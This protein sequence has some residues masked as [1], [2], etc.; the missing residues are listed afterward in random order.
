[1]QVSTVASRTFTPQQ[2]AKTIDQSVLRQT[3]TFSDV[4]A[5]AKLSLKHG[6]RALVVDPYYAKQARDL[7]KGSD[8]LCASVCDFPHGRE[9]T[10]TRVSAVKNLLAI[11]VDEVDIVAKYHLLLEN[12]VKDFKEDIRSVVKAMSGVPLKIIL[13]VDNLTP[14]QIKKATSLICEVAKEESAKN[15]IVKTKTGFAQKVNIQNIDAVKLIRQVLD[16]NKLYAENIEEIKNGK[17]GIKA[18]SGMKSKDDVIPALNMGAHIIGT[19]S[20]VDI[21]GES[22]GTVSNPNSY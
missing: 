17:L 11:G 20:G 4:E 22:A 12:N 10:D 14:E 8:V 18:S 3:H 9:T 19:S 6:F 5:N 16:E 1:M 15:L 2:L 7:L 21:I 13:E